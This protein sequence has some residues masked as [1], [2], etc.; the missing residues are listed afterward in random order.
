MQSSLPSALLATERNFGVNQLLADLSSGLSTSLPGCSTGLPLGTAL[1]HS[2]T[3]A[4]NKFLQWPALCHG[5]APPVR[6]NGKAE[7]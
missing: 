3:D 6:E 1:L 4:F 7:I 5:F 2:G